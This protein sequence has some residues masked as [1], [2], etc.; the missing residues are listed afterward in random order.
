MNIW[1]YHRKWK[2]ARA[3]TNWGGVFRESFEQSMHIF[4]EKQKTSA[5]SV[6]KIRAM[7]EAWKPAPNDEPHR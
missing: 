6:A 1:A 7:W 5:W 2:R 3:L 4:D